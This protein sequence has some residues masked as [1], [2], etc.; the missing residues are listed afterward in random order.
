MLVHGLAHWPFHWASM[1]AMVPLAVRLRLAGHTVEVVLYDGETDGFDAIVASVAD[2]VST[3]FDRPPVI[4]GHSYGG[5]IAREVAATVP[6]ESVVAIASPLRGARL[7]GWLAE[8]FPWYFAG[9]KGY[10]M[11]DSI[12]TPTDVDVPVY[13]VS[14]GLP[15]RPDFD[16]CVYRD[17]ATH[18]DGHVHVPWSEHR[19]APLDPRVWSAIR[20]F[21]RL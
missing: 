14:V 18:T 10:A 19:V 15:G 5:V 2:I 11:I 1:A 8:R 17:E 12:T 13:T 16:S 20:T 7:I 21:A 4:I 9:N 3:R 6:V